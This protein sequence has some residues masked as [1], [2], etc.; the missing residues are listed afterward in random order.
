VIVDR[1]DAAL[2]I[3]KPIKGSGGAPGFAQRTRWKRT[4]CDLAAAHP[5]K[6]R[7]ANRVVIGAVFAILDGSVV[8]AARRMYTRCPEDVPTGRHG[9]PEVGGTVPRVR[10]LSL[11]HGRCARLARG[12]RWRKVGR[13]GSRRARAVQG[14]KFGERGK[15]AAVR[16]CRVAPSPLQR[17]S[18]VCR[19]PRARVVSRF[20]DG[21]WGHAQIDRWWDACDARRRNP[22]CRRRAR[23]REQDVGVEQS[24]RSQR[25]GGPGASICDRWAAA[26]RRSRWGRRVD[27]QRV[28]VGRAPHQKTHSAAGKGLRGDL[29]MKTR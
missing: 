23:R 25:S 24:G 20:G 27:F 13:Q 17:G 29:E 2:A 12:H 19:V 21:W 26:D 1:T 22:R 16:A 10:L 8:V 28:R 14:S 15:L 3:A 18:V 4:I 9:N 7:G 5:A 6:G 11:L